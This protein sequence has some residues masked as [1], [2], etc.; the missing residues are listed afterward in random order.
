MPA[1]HDLCI[2]VTTVYAG[3]WPHGQ[4]QEHYRIVSGRGSK[5]HELL[6]RILIGDPFVRNRMMSVT[7][8]KALETKLLQK[9]VKNDRRRFDF[10]RP[11]VNFRTRRYVIVFDTARS[12]GWIW[13][14]DGA[15]IT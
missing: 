2:Q 11:L 12:E 6:K 5:C 10:Y 8:I 15:Y 7:I 4:V 3:K 14:I 9:A 13:R 1:S